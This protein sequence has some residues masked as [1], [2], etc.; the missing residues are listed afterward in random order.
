ML[1]NH[2]SFKVAENFSLLEA[3]HPGRIDL[4]IGR[5]S[6]TDALTAYAL[7]R[8]QEVVNFPEQ[9]NELLSFFSR[10]F[11]SYLSPQMTVPVLRAYKERF[12]PS[13]FMSVPRSIVST[14]VITAETDDEAKYLAAPL[15][16]LWARMYAGTLMQGQPFPSLEEAHSHVYSLAEKEAR[17]ENRN[18]FIIGGIKTVSDQLRN[19]ASETMVDEVM[20]WEAYTDKVARHKAYKLLAD[21]FKLSSTH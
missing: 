8:S 20:L 13:V 7:R 5:A 17:K 11:A 14:I 9:L 15:E 16:L 18:R 4:G 1:P 19:L 10:N 12:K 6:G 21:E 3:A 2:S